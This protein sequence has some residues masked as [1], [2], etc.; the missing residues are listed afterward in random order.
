MSE[1]FDPLND[2]KIDHGETLEDETESDT[3]DNFSIGSINFG[4]INEGYQFQAGTLTEQDGDLVLNFEADMFH[5]LSVHKL[6]P[7]VPD[8][9]YATTHAACFD[10]RAYFHHE[11]VSIWHADNEKHMVEGYERISVAPGARILVPTGMILDIPDNWSVRV[12][13]RSGL[14]LKHGIN[15]INGEG[16]IDSDYT[17]QLYVPLINNS[18]E[19]WEVTHGDRV[20]QAEIV[21]LIQTDFRYVETAPGQKGNRA[22]GFGSTGH[23]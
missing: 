7:D 18:S 19:F 9:H 16:V 6:H 20:A 14:A 1:E 23:K 17:N 15:L 21:P 4:P 8:L 11:Q 2:I 5:G 13:P 10:L 12:H 22:G 3:S